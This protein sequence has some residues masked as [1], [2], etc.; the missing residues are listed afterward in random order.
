MKKKARLIGYISIVCWCPLLAGESYVMLIH[1]AFKI[2]D[3]T[4]TDSSVKNTPLHTTAINQVLFKG[5]VDP[6]LSLAA[7]HIL[8]A[9]HDISTMN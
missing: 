3:H 1:L 2:C 4:P 6:D 9:C 5:L 7:V 8:P